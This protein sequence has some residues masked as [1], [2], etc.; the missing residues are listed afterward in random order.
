MAAAPRPGSR[1]AQ[2]YTQFHAYGPEAALELG[3]SLEL[4]TGTVK[5]WLAVWA[6]QK[7][8]A[9]PGKSGEPDP[10]TKGIAEAYHADAEYMVATRAARLKARALTQRIKS[11]ERKV[12]R[13]GG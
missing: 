3:T 6:K 2:V 8:P 11:A 5:S 1:K 9:K 4:A 7:E 13:G 12:K 10:W